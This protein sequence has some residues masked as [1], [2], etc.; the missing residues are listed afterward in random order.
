[1]EVVSVRIYSD[2]KLELTQRILNFMGNF[3]FFIF[4]VKKIFEYKVTCTFNDVK[5]FK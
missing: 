3:Y 5:T 4:Y 1:M 2:C